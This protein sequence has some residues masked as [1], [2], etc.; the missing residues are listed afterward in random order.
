MFIYLS[1]LL[2]PLSVIDTCCSFASCSSY[3]CVTCVLPV[4][5][6]CV[7]CVLPVC[8]LCVTCVLPVLSPGR[9]FWMH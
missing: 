5:Y 3:L 4:C 9:C 1:V 2:L 6:L 7:T 8:Y